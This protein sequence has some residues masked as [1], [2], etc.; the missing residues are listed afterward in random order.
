MSDVDFSPAERPCSRSSPVHR[1][2]GTARTSRH[3]FSSTARTRCEAAHHA[4]SRT[5]RR[6]ERCPTSKSRPI[7]RPSRPADRRRYGRRTSQT[8][9]PGARVI[10]E[11]NSRLLAGTD[12]S[13]LSRARTVV[14]DV[15]LSR[16][17]IVAVVS[18]AWSYRPALDGVRAVAV[19]AVVL[20][21]SGV[22]SRPADSSA[23]ICSL[24][25]V[26]SS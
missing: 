26:A 12:C 23:S 9:G 21:H 14:S 2:D 13:P 7:A 4:R 16:C 22:F 17:A 8:P 18:S 3:T 15:G 6:Q 19:Y 25:S 1:S 10:L 24:C 11:R 5:G 20:F